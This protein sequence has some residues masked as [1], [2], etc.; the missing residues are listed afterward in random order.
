VK[1]IIS[2]VFNGLFYEE[3]VIGFLAKSLD[4]TLLNWEEYS[5][6]AITVFNS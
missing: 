6:N 5:N 3:D 1:D 2:F 4:E